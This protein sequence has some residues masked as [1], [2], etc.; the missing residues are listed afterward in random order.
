MASP[1]RFPN[2]V[3]QVRFLPRAQCD[4]SG[5]RADM[6][7]DIVPRSARSAVRLVVAT[8]VQDQLT[9]QL[10]V[11]GDHPNVQIIDEEK[12]PR[13]DELAAEPDVVQP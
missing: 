13:A 2:R 4:V 12:D 8:R 1:H 7:R 5:H 6:S 9:E 10:S 11:F 3:S